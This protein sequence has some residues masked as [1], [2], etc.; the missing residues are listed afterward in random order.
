[1][2]NYTSE[3]WTKDMVSTKIIT[4]KITINKMLPKIIL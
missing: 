1:M 2:V 4:I 3:T